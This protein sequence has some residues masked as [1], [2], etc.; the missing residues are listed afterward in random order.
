MLN[1]TL[2]VSS[3]DLQRDH[4]NLHAY[5][6]IVMTSEAKMGHIHTPETLKWFPVSPLDTSTSTF[7]KTQ[8]P[9]QGIYPAIN[10]Q[11][12]PSLACP[13]SSP[14]SPVWRLAV[15]MEHCCPPWISY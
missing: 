8:I 15:V 2:T 5:C 3:E 1:S 4:I 7:V 10:S 9:A 12:L 11:L 14:P 13:P 6:Y